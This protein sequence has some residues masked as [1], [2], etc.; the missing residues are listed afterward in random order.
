S[1]VNINSRQTVSYG[2][3]LQVTAQSPCLKQGPLQ[4]K[5]CNLFP[6]PRLPPLGPYLSFLILSYLLYV[7]IM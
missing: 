4:T 1:R 3:G 7:D 6:P 5:N 2:T